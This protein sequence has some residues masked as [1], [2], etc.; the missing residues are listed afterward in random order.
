MD[1]AS[2]RKSPGKRDGETVSE[3]RMVLRMYFRHDKEWTLR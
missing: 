3:D 1:Q 2:S